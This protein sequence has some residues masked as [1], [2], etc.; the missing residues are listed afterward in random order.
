MK[1]VNC[2]HRVCNAQRVTL[3]G[4]WPRERDVCGMVVQCINCGYA[5]EVLV[6]EAVEAV[7]GN[8]IAFAHRVHF[9]LAS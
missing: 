6:V 5:N 8:A 4:G 9:A 1:R 7:L 3:V 2:D